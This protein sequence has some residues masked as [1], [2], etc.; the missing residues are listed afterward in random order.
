M[1]LDLAHTFRALRH[2]NFRRYFTGQSLSLIGTWMQQVAM[3]WL[4][5]RLSGSAWLLGVVAFCANIFILLLGPFA[6][7]LA[8]RVDRV[9][10]LY[11]TQT[12]LALQATTLAVLTW[13]G[14][15]EVWHLI[16]LATFAGVVA[17][18][19]VPLRQTL[20]VSL[21][22]D[23]SVLPNAIALNSFMVNAARVIGPAL[24]GALLALAT[25]AV[26]FALNAFSFVAV[27]AALHRVH[28]PK[29]APSASRGGF[30]DNWNEGAR[31]AFGFAPIRSVL[32]V[33]AAAA[34]TISPYSSLMPIFAKD[35]Y[36][37]GPQTL[38]W[39]LSAAGAGALASTFYLAGRDTIV[40]LGRVIALAT[41]AAGLALAAFAFLRV[42][43]VGVLLMTLVGG[44]VI[45]AAS[46]TNTVLQTIV[47]DRLRGRVLGFFTMAFLGV[48]P[49]GNLAAGALA[50][51]FGA[52]A[53]FA[54]NGLVCAAA[55]LWFWSRLPT[56]TA[57]MQPTYKRLGLVSDE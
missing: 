18:F 14:W 12:L 32:L 52:P 31:Y 7:V 33:I 44:G 21:V 28:W 11:L 57:A 39:L 6:G 3:G 46:S 54:F 55:G 41:V 2:A 37:G 34:W 13:F 9:R 27:L 51:Q 29:T 19:D 25:E 49:L 43:A 48:A 20:Y 53:T 35:I 23:R 4:T 8:D 47:E 26:C 30:L 56:L 24:A 15:V 22:D 50:R 42:F 16:A 5:Y 17:A 36:G 10:A 1:K 38:G 40:G 45:L